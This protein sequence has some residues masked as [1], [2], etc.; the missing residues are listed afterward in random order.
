MR[1]ELRVCFEGKDLIFSL[2]DIVSKNGNLMLN[3]GPDQNGV[4]PDVQKRVLL[5][6]GR[7]MTVHGPA[8]YGSRPYTVAEVNVTIAPAAKV[9][10]APLNAAARF[11][12]NATMDTLFVTLLAS[13]STSEVLAITIPNLSWPNASSSKPTCSLLSMV[14][15][16]PCMSVLELDGSIRV[17]VEPHGQDSGFPARTVQLKPAPKYT[18]A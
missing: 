11:T 14:G 3:I 16:Q 17:V 4:I 13:L 18:G 7:W 2:V 10:V 15:A 6:L 9:L 8:I 5:E 12:W 1:E